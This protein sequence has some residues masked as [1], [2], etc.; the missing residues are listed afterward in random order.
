MIGPNLQL[1]STDINLPIILLAHNDL[2]FQNHSVF[3]L[4]FMVL[5]AI[6]LRGIEV[7]AAQE[8]LG[9]ECIGI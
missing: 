6:H 7:S 4:I 3:I 9:L 8:M 5:N 2:W 1:R